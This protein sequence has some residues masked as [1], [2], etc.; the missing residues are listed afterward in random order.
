MSARR[1]AMPA[2][3]PSPQ[4]S[5]AASRAPAPRP[6]PATSS[7][8]REPDGV[9][10]RLR[11]RRGRRRGTPPPFRPTRSRAPPGR[12]SSSRREHVGERERV[13]AESVEHAAGRARPEERPALRSA[14]GW[15]GATTP[16][17]RARA[18]RERL[19]VQGSS[20]DLVP[21]R[22]G[23]DSEPAAKLARQ[24]LQD[25]QAHERIPAQ[26]QRRGAAGHDVRQTL[27]GAHEGRGQVVADD[28]DVAVVD[29]ARTRRRAPVASRRSAATRAGSAGPAR[30]GPPAARPSTASAVPASAPAS[31]ATSQP[32]QPGP[33]RR[34]HGR[35]R[36][37]PQ[38]PQLG[39]VHHRCHQR[40][41]TRCASTF[42]SIERRCRVPG[43]PA[44]RPSKRRR[45]SSCLMPAR[46]R[47]P[48]RTRRHGRSA[49]QWTA[50]ASAMLTWK[51]ADIATRC[52][53]PCCPS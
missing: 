40:R 25:R 27:V 51:C 37:L 7:R 8:P 17:S 26:D 39:A 24:H 5:A 42:S 32:E 22:E 16:S 50:L 30:R 52:S 49:S 45:A 1:A 20:C 43:R 46:G 6:T 48:G 47:A 4:M 41:V 10:D 9:R 23:D 13:C 34:L 29:G 18:H 33:E 44:R 35:P 31:S 3:G 53:R 2:G 12:R 19:R 15:P 21:R 28:V 36:R 38:P 11:V 14:P